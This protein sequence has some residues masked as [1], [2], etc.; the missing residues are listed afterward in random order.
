MKTLMGKECAHLLA[1][2]P[3]YLVDYKG[4]GA[5]SQE[6]VE[7]DASGA[8]WDD[9]KGEA[10]G[11]AFF[12]RLLEVALA[13]CHERARSRGLPAPPHRAPAVCA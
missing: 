7:V 8:H 4:C 5:K 13:H 11:L 6:V 1:T 12:S 9:Y 2:D 10:D 3:P